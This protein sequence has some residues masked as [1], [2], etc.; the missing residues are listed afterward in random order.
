MKTNLWL[1]FLLPIVLM[2]CN[3]SG[4]EV[5]SDEPNEGE[6]Y[7]GK[8]V[9]EQGAVGVSEMHQSLMA[10]GSFEGKVKGEVQEVCANKGCWM[11]MRLPDGEVLR[12]TFKDYGFFVPTDFHG[13]QVLVEGKGQYS[14]TDVATLRHFA[15]DAG[16]SKAEIEAIT[17]DQKQI[18]FEAVGVVLKSDS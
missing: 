16:K 11:T 15:E 6:H 13:S 7:F 9:D 5:H 12:I 18:T 14:I 17:E 8:W 1:L 10:T 2:S 3:S 4:T